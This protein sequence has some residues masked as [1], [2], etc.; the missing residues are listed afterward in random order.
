MGRVLSTYDQLTGLLVFY[1]NVSHHQV[2]LSLPIEVCCP[3]GHLPKNDAE[4][5]AIGVL[6][7]A[8]GL[9]CDPD[10]DH[11]FSPENVDVKIHKDQKNIYWDANEYKDVV[12]ALPGSWISE[13]VTFKGKATTQQ[14]T[15]LQNFEPATAATG[16]S[17]LSALVP[18]LGHAHKDINHVC[19]HIADP[20][21]LSENC[22]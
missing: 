5:K 13:V 12:C 21:V 11:L 10:M 6:T 18:K 20:S 2:H 8:A 4:R 22:I 1:F 17:S 7:V 9:I 15:F 14:Q 16:Q 19:L 3:L